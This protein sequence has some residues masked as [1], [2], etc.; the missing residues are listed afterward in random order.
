MSNDKYDAETQKAIAEA[1]AL[2]AM[3]ASS[4]WK[5]AERKLNEK[6]NDFKDIAKVDLSADGD[7]VKQQ[8]RDR[9]NLVAIIEEWMREMKGTTSN[10]SR[11]QE[12]T[13]TTNVLIERR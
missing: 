2:Q 1:E 11:L 12:I 4:G 5:I 7:E 8:L 3:F 10:V 6:L 9:I 13:E